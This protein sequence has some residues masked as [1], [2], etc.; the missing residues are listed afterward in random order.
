MDVFWGGGEKV[1]EREGEVVKRVVNAHKRWCIHCWV[2]IGRKQRY[3]DIKRGGGGGLNGWM[4]LEWRGVVRAG[5]LGG[6]VNQTSAFS[7]LLCFLSSFLLVMVHR[8]VTL[9]PLLPALGRGLTL[10]D[11]GM[12]S[13]IV[14][15]KRVRS[16]RRK[17]AASVRYSSAYARLQERKESPVSDFFFS[18]RYKFQFL[19]R[20]SSSP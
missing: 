12:T 20:Y 8:T 3:K 6:Y 15:S 11:T 14:V 2:Y 7:S 18:V 5:R 1:G 4:Y 9:T 16:K 13:S 10:S 19:P 17:T